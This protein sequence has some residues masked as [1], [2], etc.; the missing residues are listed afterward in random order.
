MSRL[1]PKFVQGALAV[2]LA[3]SSSIAPAG[4]LTPQQ[5]LDASTDALQRV[6]NLSQV[7]KPTSSDKARLRDAAAEGL[8]HGE[9]FLVTAKMKKKATGFDAEFQGHYLA[10]LRK[11][12]DGIDTNNSEMLSEGARLI[13][14]FVDWMQTQPRG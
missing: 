8:K 11:I 10:G 5:E 1:I 3:V 2:A 4:A 13:N 6:I 12:R 14:Q 7:R 9:N